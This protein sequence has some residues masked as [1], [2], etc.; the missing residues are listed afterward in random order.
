MCREPGWLGGGTITKGT[1][2]GFAIKMQ[3]EE[4]DPARHGVGRASA[5]RDVAV[6]IPALNE[7]QSLPLVLDELPS[8]GRVL[9]VNNGST[10]DTAAVGFGRGATVV[11]EPKRGYGAACLRGGRHLRVDC[12][13]RT[14]AAGGGFPGRGL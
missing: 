11:H 6:I 14:S 5:V 7:E 13:G 10:D 12:S 2:K 8:V 4:Q 3:S 1:L 9:V